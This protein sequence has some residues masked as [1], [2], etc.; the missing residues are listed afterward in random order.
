MEHLEE[1]IRD[2][3]DG[4]KEHN[5]ADDIRFKEQGDTMAEIKTMVATLTQK[6]DD[7]FKR[8][9][10]K[11]DYANGRTAKVE[12][13]AEANKL[14]VALIHQTLQNIVDDRKEVKKGFL[15]VGFSV[16]TQLI[17]VVVGGLL[18]IGFQ[19]YINKQNNKKYEE[20]R[21]QLSDWEIVK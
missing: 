8:I 10:E 18:V 2:I 17:I 11:Q 20:L 13:Q 21:A 6:V 12:A 15:G 9:T 1:H 14:D 16:L 3:K 7:G 19:T 5:K 4:M